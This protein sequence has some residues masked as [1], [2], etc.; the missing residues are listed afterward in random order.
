MGMYEYATE[1]EK[2]ARAVIE[3]LPELAFID[4][5]D[6]RVGFLKCFREK[7][8]G[9]LQRVLGECCKV[10]DM[11]QVFAPYDFLI[12]IYEPNVAALSEN[13]LK[14]LLW[15]ELKH[16][17]VDEK[18]GTLQYI[19]VPHDVE[20]FDS[21]IYRVGLRW[22]TPGAQVPDILAGLSGGDPGGE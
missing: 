3:V 7:K 8:R 17:G 22:S 13:Q 10:E 11:Y 18:N 2:L 15:H 21:I 19:T 12:V 6:I 5:S 9:K 4:E 16:I 14:I 20:E 1:Y